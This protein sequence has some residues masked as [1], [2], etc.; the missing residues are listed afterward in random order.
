MGVLL[1]QILF[2]PLMERLRAKTRVQSAI[3][4][5]LCDTL[6]VNDTCL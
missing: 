2:S 4:R 5:M 3:I 6:K 1:L